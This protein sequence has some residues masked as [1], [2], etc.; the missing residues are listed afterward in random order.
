[1]STQNDKQKTSEYKFMVAIDNKRS[2]NGVIFIQTNEQ[3]RA[4]KALS[5]LVSSWTNTGRGLAVFKTTTGAYKYDASEATG[6]SHSLMYEEDGLNPDEKIPQI[7]LSD[8]LIEFAKKDNSS[9]AP[10]YNFNYL[11]AVNSETFLEAETC[12]MFSIVE[13][14]LL[15]LDA[16][17]KH[18]TGLPDKETKKADTNGKRLFCIVPSSYKIS[19]KLSE[20]PVIKLEKPSLSELE[21]TLVTRILPSYKNLGIKDYSDDEIASIASNAMG[22]TDK[23]AEGTFSSVLYSES[24]DLQNLTAEKFGSLVGREKT[25]MIN[26]SPVLTVIDS[27]NMEDVGGLGVLKQD[28]KEAAFSMTPKARA[29]GIDPLKGITLI[30][31]SGSGKTYVA[32]AISAVLDVPLIDF[33]VSAVLGGLVGQSEKNMTDALETIRAVK[34]CVILVDEVD[35]LFS[36][37]GSNDGGV[38]SRI[39]GLLLG[40]MQSSTDTVYVFT[41]N[42]AENL[43]VEL[44]RGGRVDTIYAMFGPTLEERKT[45]MGIH[46]RKRG[47]TIPSSLDKSAAAS[48]GF[49]SAEIE[50][51]IVKALR[52]Q[53]TTDQT[54]NVTDEL[55]CELMGE[56]NPMFKTH[57]EQHTAMAEW[58]KKNARNASFSEEVLD[59]EYD[60]VEE[61]A[62]DM[63]GI[64]KSASLPEQV[65]PV[66]RRPRR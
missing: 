32:Q 64:I 46:L 58:A 51:V 36:V 20:I 38:T 61:D 5:A 50:S 11:A 42:R 7:S 23:F 22:L 12:P 47:V 9:D 10:F 2:S 19:N 27:I 37:G 31:P 28:M 65:A 63:T 55:I 52:R 15:D 18:V 57:P 43:P 30:G 53:Y 13:Q 48:K 6:P 25:N 49:M 8:I 56:T 29:L 17:L 16:Q 26:S 59:A 35:K 33:K 66:T 54:N 40:E 60:I 4:I 34:G 62:P 44:M 41:A 3:Q 39:L 1:M 45:I 21:R 14:Q 24:N